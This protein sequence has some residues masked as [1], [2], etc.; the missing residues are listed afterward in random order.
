MRKPTMAE[1]MVLRFIENSGGL[2]KIVRARNG[3]S[4]CPPEKRVQLIQNIVETDS[5]AEQLMAAALLGFTV[6]AEIGKRFEGNL[7]QVSGEN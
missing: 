2:E 5:G 3:F 1:A 4:N 7:D 6:A